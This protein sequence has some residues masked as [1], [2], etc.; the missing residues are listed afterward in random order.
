MRQMAP[1]VTRAPCPTG[2]RNARAFASNASLCVSRWFAW[3]SWIVVWRSR[4]TSQFL[5]DRSAKASARDAHQI[6]HTARSHY[7]RGLDDGQQACRRS[8]RALPR[9]TLECRPRPTISFFSGCPKIFPIVGLVVVVVQQR[10]L[11][12]VVGVARSGRGRT[13]PAAT[14]RARRGARSSAEVA[15]AGD[16]RHRGD[17]RCAKRARHQV[18]SVEAGPRSS[19]PRASTR[20]ALALR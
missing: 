10:T 16:G 7:A 1:A 19:L 6:G 3:A 5:Q 18:R 13:A 12:H 8:Q 2:S 9:D 20:A 15:H 4:D 17:G 11:E 14:K